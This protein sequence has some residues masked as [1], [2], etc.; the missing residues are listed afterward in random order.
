MCS[1]ACNNFFVFLAYFHIFLSS[2]I[3]NIN[4][5]FYHHHHKNIYSA[6]VTKKDIGALQQSTKKIDDNVKIRRN[7]K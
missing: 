6:P 2:Q 5:D 7:T 1:C 4:E 3:S